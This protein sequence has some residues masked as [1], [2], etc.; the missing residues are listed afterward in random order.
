MNQ[1]YDYQRV[2]REKKR[3]EGDGSFWLCNPAAHRMMSDEWPKM[4]DADSLPEF[5]ELQKISDL[6]QSIR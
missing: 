6:I 3:F 1:L 5:M 4:N 2:E